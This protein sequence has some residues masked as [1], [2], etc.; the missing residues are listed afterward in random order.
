MAARPQ[1]SDARPVR[2]VFLDAGGTLIHLDRRFILQCLAGQGVEADA[3]AYVAAVRIAGRRVAD[4]MRTGEAPDDITRWRLYII[5][6]LEALGCGEEAL[7][8]VGE[9][10]RERHAEGR[11]WTHVEPDVAGALQALRQA[12]YTVGVVSNA[13]GRVADFLRW[14][15][16]DSFFD[17]I[18][19][20]ALVGAEKPDPRIF[21]IACE[22]A[23]V[24][25]EQ[26]VHVGDIYEI[27]VLGA[28]GAGVTPVLIDP[29]GLCEVRDCARIRAM[30]ELPGWLEALASATE[31]PRV[32]PA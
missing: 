20:S 25:P 15:G 13:D 28:R 29:H 6:L 7:P 31:P 23:G 19:D 2:A 3:D 17:F 24:R 21:E 14:A 32:A 12:D 5:A 27:D 30:G 1:T 11:L 8:V 9:A 18:I 4:V 16:L 26:A 22:R 10:L